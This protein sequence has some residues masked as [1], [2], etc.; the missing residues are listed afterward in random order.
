MIITNKNNIV[1]GNNALSP[2]NIPSKHLDETKYRDFEKSKRQHLKINKEKSIKKKIK[3]LT[4]IILGFT[5][6]ITLIY[7]YSLIYNIEKDITQV[8]REISKVDSQNENLKIGLLKYNNIG[9]IEKK[10]TKELNMI[11]Q[12]ISNVIYIDLKKNNFNSFSKQEDKKS[13]NLLK[14]LKDILF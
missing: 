8:N 4:N 3:V 11:P 1:S 13:N 14:K 7:R 5:I 12:S 2:Q 9:E 10:S 6:G